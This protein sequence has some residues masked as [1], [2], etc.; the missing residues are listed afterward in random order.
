VKSRRPSNAAPA[1]FSILVVEQDRVVCELQRHFLE[2]AG[3]V[4]EFIS[5][6]EAALQTAQ[7]HQPSLIVTEILIPKIDGLALC[8]CLKSDP[9]TMH[10]PVIVFS[11]LNAGA[12]A[13]EAG[14]RAFLRKPLVGATFIAAIED[15]LSP[16]SSAT[17]EQHKWVSQ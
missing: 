11:I 15:L 12:R 8:R 2:S 17:L 13:A 7:L 4:A 6:G 9:L 10:I 5:D 14:A 16:R 3:F 1:S